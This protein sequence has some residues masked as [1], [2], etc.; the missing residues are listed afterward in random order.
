MADAVS[1]H[2]GF[3]ASQLL[4]TFNMW[5]PDIDP[6]YWRIY[7]D[8][9]MSVFTRLRALGQVYQ[10]TNDTRQTFSEDYIYPTAHIGTGGITTVS[11]PAG[12]YTFVL[13]VASG[14]ND[15]LASSGS[16]PYSSAQHYPPVQVN[17]RLFFQGTSGTGLIPFTVTAVTGSYPTVTVAI[18]QADLTQTFTTANY[19]AGT[20]LYI[21]GNSWAEGTDQPDG[22]VT[23]P[24]IDY[25]Y[26]QI[27]KTSFQ[28][29]GTQMVT[30]LWMDK[31]SDS[32]GNIVGYRTIGM[33]AAELAHE[34][35]LSGALLFER[36]TTNYTFTGSNTEPN[37]TTEGYITYW[38]RRGYTINYA[39]GSFSPYMFDQIDA[40]ADKNFG[41][42][43]Y[44]F[45]MGRD[46]YNEKDN[47]LKA[48]FQNTMQAYES[49]RDVADAFGLNEGS[50]NAV[51]FTKF[52]KGRRT[53]LFTVIDEF[54]NPRTMGIA[55]YQGPGLGF[56]VPMGVKKDTKSGL[57]LPYMG[58]GER[59]LGGYNRAHEVWAVNGAGEGMKVITQDIA[60]FNFRSHVAACHVGGNQAIILE[61]I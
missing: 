23:K 15:F 2:S 51:R 5:K 53:Y 6:T 47:A 4:S 52:T 11:A 48:Y 59:S 17:D 61:R 40:Q 8:Q 29:P 54:N 22:L 28:I 58:I 36:P 7:G 35:K 20:E 16:A 44:M 14:A 55:G 41:P 31:Y 34:Y 12:T 37:K 60:K 3:P 25:E 49:S 32:G 30:G 46:L 21:G 27:I 56:A 24:Y 19:P 26:A 42:T 1:A 9:G 45:G 18:K 13:S 43:Y 57:D 10:M 50:W 33:R 38:K 39:S